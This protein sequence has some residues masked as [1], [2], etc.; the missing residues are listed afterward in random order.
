MIEHGQ[1]YRVKG[2]NLIFD[3]RV[4]SVISIE[5][6]ERGEKELKHPRMLDTLDLD[7]D[8]QVR[9]GLDIDQTGWAYYGKDAIPYF[10]LHE[11]EHVTDE[12]E[13]TS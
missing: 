1:K 9:L 7:D 10:S 2:T 5:L 13:K 8:A 3:G 4:G 11:L 12:Q 6:A